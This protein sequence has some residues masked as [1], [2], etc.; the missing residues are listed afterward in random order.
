MV[1]FEGKGSMT[2]RNLVAI[3]RDENLT[4]GE[5]G[6]ATGA[7]IDVQ[8]AQPDK[9]ADY[10]GGDVNKACEAIAR[11]DAQRDPSINV[12]LK[13]DGSTYTKPVWYSRAQMR[14]MAA[15]NGGKLFEQVDDKGTVYAAS[16]KASVAPLRDKRTGRTNMVVLM[17]KDPSRAKDDVGRAKIEKYNA[18][19][20]IG[21]SDFGKANEVFLKRQQAASE[22]IAD[23]EH[24]IMADAMDPVLT[25]LTEEDLML[26][27]ED[28][29]VA[30]EAEADGDYYNGNLGVASDR[31]AGRSEDH[32]E[33]A[34][35]AG[36]YDD[37]VP[38]SRISTSRWTTTS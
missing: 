3:W 33:A 30:M 28:I 18:R 37:H 17:P 8:M 7:W 27:D 16:F 10:Y 19:N 9:C 36:M 23:Y 32:I 15:A 24:M 38:A 20:K 1:R 13:K 4:R 6:K 21:P 26:D 22:L 2:Q 25:G 29:G 14:Q 11:D 5:D 31:A 12:R 35:D 34:F